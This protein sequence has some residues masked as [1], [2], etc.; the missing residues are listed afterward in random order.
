MLPDLSSEFRFQTSRSSG[1]GGQNVNKVESRVEVRLSIPGSRLLTEEQKE[2][3]LRK[4]TSSLTED[5]ELVV[6]EQRTRSQLKNKELA[7]EKLLNLL[8]KAFREPKPRK[9]TRP[10]KASTEERLERK[11]ISSERKASR[12][13][14]N[15]DD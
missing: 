9:P 12:Q 13:R 2:R 6:T 10:T 14:K 8:E 7:T 3:I 1:P 5:G 11:R 15:W 4:L